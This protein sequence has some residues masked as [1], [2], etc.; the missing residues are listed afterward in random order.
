M[1]LMRL[2]QID[3]AIGHRHDGIGFAVGLDILADQKR[4]R[5]PAGHARAQFLDEILQFGDALLPGFRGLHHRAERVDKHQARRE[6]FNFLH[7]AFEHAGKIALAQVLGQV[8]VADRRPDQAG[9]EKAVLLLEAQHF[10]GWFT[11]HGKKQGAP[12]GIG[13]RKHDLVRQRGLAA[14]G[15]AG[16]EVEGEFAES[17]SEQDIQSWYACVHQPQGDFV[18]HYNCS[19]TGMAVSLAGAAS[20]SCFVSASPIKPVSNLVKV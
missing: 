8:D 9:V 11:K 13:Q 19:C 4:R 3:H 16:N 12:L 2:R 7:D 20:R 1:A 10:Q 14:A 17:A 18:V 15:R 5:F 6:R